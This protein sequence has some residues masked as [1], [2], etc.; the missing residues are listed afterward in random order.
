V[1]QGEANHKQEGV[2]CHREQGGG[3]SLLLRVAGVVK[4]SV[5]DGPGLRLTVFTQGCPH[6]CPGCH[7][8]ATHDF[9]GGWETPVAALLEELDKNPLLA[10]VTLSGGEPLCRAEELFP[11]VEGTRARGKNV[12]CFTG[13][14]FEELLELRERDCALARLL[15]MIDLLIDGRYE[16]SQRDLTLNLRGSRNQRVLDLPASLTSGEV[17]WAKGYQE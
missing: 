11:L 14:T 7:N 10:G 5:V 13:Y 16:Q 12:V 3:S 15:P 1:H 9:E 8:P 4:Q 17:V 6:K 2:S